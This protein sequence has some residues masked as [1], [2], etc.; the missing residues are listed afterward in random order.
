MES[1]LEKLNAPDN[2]ENI[3]SSED[4][5]LIG[6]EPLDNTQIKLECNHSFNYINLS[7]NH[8]FNYQHIF[9][10]AVKQKYHINKYK[11][12]ILKTNELR[13]PYCRNVQEKLLPYKKYENVERV[14][15]VNA[16]FKYTMKTH[17]CAYVYRR[18]KNKGEIC[19]KECD[20]PFCNAHAKYY[21]S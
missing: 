19:N 15:G 1:F 8:K 3:N 20:E 7:C 12:S 16:P 11:T 18:G 9:K 5:C 14:H 21:S 17:K 13:C 10:D 2:D 4:I 6:C